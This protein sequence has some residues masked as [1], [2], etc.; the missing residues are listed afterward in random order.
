M[1][2]PAPLSQLPTGGGLKPETV[3]S[4]LDSSDPVLN[5]TA[6][7]IAGHRP[8]WG[9]ALAGFF[10]QHLTAA[11]LTDAARED[12]Q[13]KLIQFAETAAIQELLAATVERATASKDRLTALRAMARTRAGGTQNAA[14]LMACRVVPVG[15]APRGA[16]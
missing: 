4:L 8:E 15:G 2:L 6:W 11:N 9:G 7:W 14:R 13:R 16:A 10:Q 12:L 5:D 3:I 1:P